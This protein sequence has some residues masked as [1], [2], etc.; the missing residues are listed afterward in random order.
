V[1]FVLQLSL[2]AFGAGT[3]SFGVI[4]VEC[5]GGLGVISSSS[6]VLMQLP[7]ERIAV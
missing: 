1:E 3:D 4:A 7:G 6:L 2:C 5:S